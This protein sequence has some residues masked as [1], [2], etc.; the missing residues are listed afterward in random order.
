M[1]AVLATYGAAL[2]VGLAVVSFPA[3]ATVLKA[4]HGLSD[5]KYGA[6]FLPQVLL[7]IL[8]SL[9][10]GALSERR[11]LRF[12]L[13]LSLVAFALAEAALFGTSTTNQGSAYLLLLAGTGSAGVGFGLAAAPLNTLP[14]LL[15]PLRKET[16]LVALHTC[17]GAGFA[18]GPV[19]VGRFVANGAWAAAPVVLGVAALV[20]LVLVL[21]SSLPARMRSVAR[22][23][24]S[25]VRLQELAPFFF[26]AALYAFAEGTFANW[27]V[28]FLH[29]ERG[30]S[31]PQAA[32]ALASFWAALALGRL[33]VSALLIRVSSRRIW[34]FL[35]LVMA[36]AAVG[37]PLS[38]GPVSGI[39]AFSIAGVGCS[40]FFP[41]TV[42]SAVATD[43]ARGERISSAMTAALML[44]VGL[45][46]FTVGPLRSVCSIGQV[47]LLS[48]LYPLSALA[49][50]FFAPANGAT[51]PRSVQTAS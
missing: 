49:L 41:L 47:Y 32:L 2:V 27:S 28:V 15:F 39:L 22:G 26:I 42:H 9:A 11:S 29:E 30:V 1:L 46:S 14:G 18:V 43:P 31:E 13:G 19:L 50:A 35:P 36:G 40:A 25:N 33:V 21:A 3:S 17:I 44:G 10:G 16:A 4:A 34:F 45:G 6:I 38:H 7:T 20:G 37:I 48:A 12:V 23:T 51:E 24:G 8:G 5:S